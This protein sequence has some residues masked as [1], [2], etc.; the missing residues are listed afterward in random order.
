MKKFP[1]ALRKFPPATSLIRTVS[2]DY[3]MPDSNVVLKKGMTALISIYGIHHDEKIYEN[4]EKY[5]PDR[6]LPENVS[7]RHAMAFIPFGKIPFDSKRFFITFS[8]FL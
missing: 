8:L 5:D 4:P 3:K 1:E 7:K 6:F 2:K